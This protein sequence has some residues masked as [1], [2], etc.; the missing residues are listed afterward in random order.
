MGGASQP[1][2]L[3]RE[4]CIRVHAGA[5]EVQNFRRLTRQ[6]RAELM[7]Q[8]R[9]ADT[10]IAGHNHDASPARSGFVPDLEQ[11]RV[12]GGTTDHG[13]QERWR[14]GEAALAV[15]GAFDQPDVDG[16]ADALELLLPQ[17]R[18]FEC[19]A[20]EF[21]GCRPYDDA[22]GRRDFL[23]P[24]RDMHRHP[25]HFSPVVVSLAGHSTDN[26]DPG[27]DRDSH[28]Q[29]QKPGFARFE[30]P[31]TNSSG[32]GQSGVYCALTIVFVGDWKTEVRQE[33]RR[34]PSALYCRRNLLSADC[35][36]HDRR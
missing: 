30:L 15:R 17:R 6:L 29:A 5:L 1:L 21:V 33:L 24:R 26:D 25:E 32:D 13:R 28:P 2:D 19:I 7:D 11:R 20:D 10:R 34:R 8:S 35:K 3:R 12:L 27:I 22:I 9:L 4:R 18:T 31:F 36:T 16:V 14:L 23:H